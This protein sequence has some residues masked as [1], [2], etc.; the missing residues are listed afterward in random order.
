MSLP[1]SPHAVVFDMDGLLLD[2]ETLY[3]AAVVAAA[4]AIGHD[5]PKPLFL[6]MLG[7][8]WA[9][10]QHQALFALNE[11]AQRRRTHRVQYLGPHAFQ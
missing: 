11:L 4:G 8:P 3:H 5:F 6:Q 7:M 2:S 1:R 10:N 9:D